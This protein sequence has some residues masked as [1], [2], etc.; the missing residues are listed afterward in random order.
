MQIG[1][2]LLVHMDIDGVRH[3]QTGHLLDHGLWIIHQP[4][5]ESGILIGPSLDFVFHFH[6]C[7]HLIAS[8]HGSTE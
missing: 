3:V 1:G 6:C 8:S 7:F 2:A 5:A 4:C